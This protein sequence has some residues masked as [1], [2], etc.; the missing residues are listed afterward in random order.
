MFTRDFMQ[1]IPQDLLDEI[2]LLN[3]EAGWLKAVTTPG[4]EIVCADW[5][6]AKY[7]GF[8]GIGTVLEG[9]QDP[10]N[11]HGRSRMVM[12]ECI[13]QGQKAQRF[14]PAICLTPVQTDVNRKMN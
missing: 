8:D 7:D 10:V 9:A 4:S 3:E 2:S 11:G 13:F 1:L 5:A 12:V 6:K 14:Y